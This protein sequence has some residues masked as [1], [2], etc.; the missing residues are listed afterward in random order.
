MSTI[1]RPKAEAIAFM[2]VQRFAALCDNPANQPILSFSHVEALRKAIADTIMDHTT[3]I[4]AGYD[5]MVAPDPS[6]IK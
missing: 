2:A 1:S 5:G 3:R 4:G 6:P